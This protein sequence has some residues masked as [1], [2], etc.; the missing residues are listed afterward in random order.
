[1]AKCKLCGKPLYQNAQ[2][3]WEHER[4]AKPDEHGGRRAA[5]EPTPPPDPAPPP[6]P[7][8]GTPPPTPPPPEPPETPP[9][10]GHPLSRRIGGKQE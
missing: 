8:P 5:P 2:G 9:E 1:M 7:P 4:R 3:E 10:R 6:T